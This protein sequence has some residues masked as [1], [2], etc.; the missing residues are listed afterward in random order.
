VI[1]QSLYKK[2]V[3]RCPVSCFVL[4]TRTFFKEAFSRERVKE[5]VIAT[6]I[7]EVQRGGREGEETM[8]R[9]R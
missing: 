2:V 8:G 7:N 9:A 5:I 4:G 6:A 1:Q 3:G